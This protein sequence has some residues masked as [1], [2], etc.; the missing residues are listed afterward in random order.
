MAPL[1]LLARQDDP[2]AFAAALRLHLD[3][4]AHATTRLIEGQRVL[5][6]SDSTTV[7]HAL[8]LGRPR[9]V[10]CL[11]S[12]PGG[13]GGA[14]AERL[15]ARLWEDEDLA[16]AAARADIGLAGADAVGPA[17]FVNKVGTAALCRALPTWL[18]A[19]PEKR[20]SRSDFDA[21]ARAT[22]GLFEVVPLDLVR[23][24]SL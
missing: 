2:A 12:M 15:G 10:H 3:E 23:D 24:L 5:T 16:L 21:C 8:R 11:R 18:L 20:L 9:E 4:A 14:L 1:R 7:E 22:G 6:I 19:V 13:E 17:A